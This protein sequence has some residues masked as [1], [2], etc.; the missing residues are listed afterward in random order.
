[1]NDVGCCNLEYPRRP[2]SVHHCKWT[3]AVLALLAI[4]YCL[5]QH[6]WPWRT[7]ESIKQ[8]DA[9]WSKPDGPDRLRSFQECAI[10]NLL[11]TGLPFLDNASPIVISDYEERRDRL[12]EAL[13]A[14][15]ADAFVVEPG[16]TFK[17]YGNVSQPEWEVWEV[18]GSDE[19][20]WMR[21]A[22]I[23]HI[24]AR[25]APL[26]DGRETHF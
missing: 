24:T 8:L 21:E 25:G 5:S 1:M 12:A 7:R 26:L 16:Y 6:L 20:L 18:S 13:I 15:G 11:E 14:E 10:N 22:T 2:H 23:S 17:Y 4:A 19:T 9:T 3:V